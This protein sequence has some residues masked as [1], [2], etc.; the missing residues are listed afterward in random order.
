MGFKDFFMFNRA[1]FI[2]LV[3]FNVLANFGF[4]K[5][6]GVGGKAIGAG[7]FDIFSFFSQFTCATYWS[8]FCF[9]WD[10]FLKA[11]VI[12]LNLVWQLFLAN[13]VVFVYHK[14]RK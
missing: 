3:L 12:M 5:L 2:L 6:S 9:V 14:I 7:I 11:F 8:Y 10:P 13:L 4:L 1:T